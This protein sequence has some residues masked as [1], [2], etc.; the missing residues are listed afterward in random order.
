MVTGDRRMTNAEAF[1][2]TLKV[3]TSSD[4]NDYNSVRLLTDRF[5]VKTLAQGHKDA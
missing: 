2:T 1:D 4:P 3:I 5:E